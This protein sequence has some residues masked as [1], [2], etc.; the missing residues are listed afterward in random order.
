M[1]QQKN[2]GARPWDL[3]SISIHNNRSDESRMRDLPQMLG[4]LNSFSAGILVSGQ[5]LVTFDRFYQPGFLP[6]NLFPSAQYL[7]LFNCNFS[8]IHAFL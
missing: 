3:H 8:K 4:F 1:L 5:K 2:Y 7:Y 6:L